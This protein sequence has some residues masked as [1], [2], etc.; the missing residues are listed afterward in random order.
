MLKPKR[1]QH[2]D[3]Y[4]FSLAP[5][6]GTYIL[7]VDYCALQS[8]GCSPGSHCARQGPGR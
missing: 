3:R 7:D 5:A 6:D 1:T 2:H 4:A 8:A